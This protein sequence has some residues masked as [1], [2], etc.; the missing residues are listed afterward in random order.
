MVRA[1]SISQLF[2]VSATARSVLARYIIA[3]LILGLLTVLSFTVVQS[4]IARMQASEDVVAQASELRSSIHKTM[5]ALD[6]I[7]LGDLAEAREEAR[8]EAD[9]LQG[10][11]SKLLNT[12]DRSEPDTEIRF[13]MEDAHY[14]LERQVR[15]LI[16]RANGVDVRRQEPLHAPAAGSRNAISHS[17]SLTHQHDGSQGMPHSANDA[18]GA[19]A[20]KAVDALIKRLRDHAHAE[21]EH[22]AL[23]HN[24]LGGGMLVIL[25]IEASIIFRPLLRRAES[26]TRRADLVTSELEYLAAHDALTGLL[27]RGQVDRVLSVA[28]EEAANTNRQ[29]GLILLDLDRFKAINDTL[30]HAAGDAVLVAVAERIQSV[31]CSTNI[32]GRLGGDEFIVIL[33]DVQKEAEVE[34]IAI[35]LLSS[36][37]EPVFFEGAEIIPDASIGYAMFPIAGSDV[38]ALLSAADLAMYN[39]KRSGRGR[40]SKFSEQ[41]RAESE[42]ARVIDSEI[43]GALPSGQFEV[44]YQTIHEAKSGRSNAAEALI[45]WRHPRRGLLTPDAFLGDLRRTGQMDALTSF[46]LSEVISQ[47]S[48]WRRSGF[49]IGTVHVNVA[50]EFLLK[51]GALDEVKDLL[52]AHR[53]APSSLVIEIPEETSLT[54]PTVVTAI[55][56]FHAAGIRVAVDDFGV[57][58]VSM[59]HLCRPSLSVIKIDRLLVRDITSS[60]ECRAMMMSIAEMFRNMGKSVI[61][62]GV[63]SKHEAELLQAIGFDQFQGFFWARPLPAGDLVGTAQAIQPKVA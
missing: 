53:I 6:R 40:I 9:S 41:M 18:H 27:N 5:L 43:R 50:E 32:G 21:Q 13:I 1:V 61:V 29:L 3:L 38:A 45:R 17:Q 56:G 59:H 46:V 44:H 16:E 39:A 47:L 62:E 30:G 55:E 11:L 54:D 31:L 25:L 15:M 35:Q 49:D 12:F 22:A 34:A 58:T 60:S 28:V 51:S 20:M 23:V 8:L 63:E 19:P 57:G 42:R 36:I 37:S 48:N 10:S 33:P 14:G 24:A 4:L 2:L 26:E 52:A 7:S